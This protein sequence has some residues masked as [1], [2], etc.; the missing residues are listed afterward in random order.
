MNPLGWLSV[1][2]PRV[3][4]SQPFSMIE[5][6]LMKHLVYGAVLYAVLTPAL[7]GSFDLADANNGKAQVERHCMSCHVAKFGGDGSSIY[8]RPDHKVRS[9]EALVAQ[10]NRCNEGTHA[11]L[12]TEGLQDV[13]A[14]LNQTF[15]KFR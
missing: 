12:P 4:Q 9:Q 5:E 14:Y 6:E 3:R 1:E 15:Y 13:G 2:P 7:A 10:I 8:T 11:G